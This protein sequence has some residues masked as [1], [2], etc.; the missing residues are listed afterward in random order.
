MKVDDKTT[1]SCQFKI[2][3]PC[4]PACRDSRLHGIA[5]RHERDVLN[6]IHRGGLFW[7][8][9]RANCLYHERESQQKHSEGRGLSRIEHSH[10]LSPA[11]ERS[12]LISSPP[13]G[14]APGLLPGETFAKTTESGRMSLITASNSASPRDAITG[15][16][17]PGTKRMARDIDG[18]VLETKTPLSVTSSTVAPFSPGGRGGSIGLSECAA[19]GGGFGTGLTN[20][21]R[22]PP[23]LYSYP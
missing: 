15:A 23:G 6:S 20:G 9:G 8:G 18:S 16:R 5:S 7:T 19:P 17:S 10:F 4:R 2:S 1:R 21:S 22:R 11:A 3:K 14:A 12:F 13:S